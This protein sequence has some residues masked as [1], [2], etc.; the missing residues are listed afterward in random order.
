[1]VVELCVVLHDR[2]ERCCLGRPQ[3]QLAIRHVSR[4]TAEVP[5]PVDDAAG[6]R[7]EP[8]SQRPAE[9]LPGGVLVAGPERSVRLAPGEPCPAERHR[10]FAAG[11]EKIAVSARIVH[12][13]QTVALVT[14]CAVQITNV[15]PPGVL[16]TVGL[17]TVN[18]ELVNE[19][20]PLLGPPLRCPRVTEV[21]HKTEREPPSAVAVRPKRTVRGHLLHQVAFAECRLSIRFQLA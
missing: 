9:R 18:T 16:T 6:C 12:G 3:I 4:E 10:G 14:V 15:T 1:M 19:V 2:H 13:E 20:T 17:E 7:G 5:T 21:G 8:G 11:L